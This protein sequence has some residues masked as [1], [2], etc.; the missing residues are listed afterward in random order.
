MLYKDIE[1]FKVKEEKNKKWYSC[2]KADL[3][4][5]GITQDEEKHFIIIKGSI[6][7]ENITILILYALIGKCLYIWQKVTELKEEN[8]KIIL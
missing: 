1:R 2:I 8:S 3:K 5:S 7:C 4:L 6:H